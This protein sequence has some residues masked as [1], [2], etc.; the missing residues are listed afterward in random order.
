M[1]SLLVFLIVGGAAAYA[2][3]QLAPRVLRGWLIGRLRVVAP[4]RRT[5]LARLEASAESTGC[6]S[7]KGCPG[8]APVRDGR[9]FR[10]VDCGDA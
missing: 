10:E 4:R 2:A 5:W 7:C 6:A 8:A 9:V 1:Q 3:W